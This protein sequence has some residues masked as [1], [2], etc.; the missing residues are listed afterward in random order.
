MSFEKSLLS[1]IIKHIYEHFLPYWNGLN[2]ICF[3]IVGILFSIQLNMY[4]WLLLA[5]SIILS[6][7]HIYKQVNYTKTIEKLEIEK[8]EEIK[9]I[10]ETITKYELNIQYLENRLAKINSNSIALIETNLAYLS[11]KIKLGS[12]GRITLYKFIDEQ[13]YILGRYSENPEFKKRSRESY[14]KEGLIFKAWQEGKFC[15]TNGIPICVNK[16]TKFRSGY[17]KTLNDIAPIKEETVWDMKM[18]SRCFYLK[19]L[20]DASLLENN[21]I[22]VIES[23]QENGFKENTIDSVLNADEEKKLVN[24]VEKIDWVFPNSENAKEKGF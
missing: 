19:T 13:F 24:F 23:I 8:N 5:I 2:M 20:K 6:G 10:E 9:N 15:K 21:S 11:E 22:I 4:G 12:D 7:L 1:K 14:P 17:F 18:K 3:T 16:R